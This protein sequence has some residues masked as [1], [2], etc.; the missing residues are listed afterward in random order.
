MFKAN[1]SKK[2]IAS[3]VGL[4][5]QRIAQILT[6][7]GLREKNLNYSPKITDAIGNNILSLNDKGL[8]ATE[9]SKIIGI[10]PQGIRFFLKKNNLTSNIKV[11]DRTRPCAVCGS[12]FT[13]KYSDGVKK[14]KYK[15]C[16]EECLHKHLSIVKTKYNEDDINKVIKLK[17]EFIPNNRISSETGIDINKIKEITKNY[18]LFLTKE[19]GQRNAYESKLAKNPN[20]I[21]DMKDKY[22][23][24]VRSDETLEQVKVQLQGMGFEYV[25]GFEIKSKPFTIKCLTCKKDKEICRINSVVSGSCLLCAK[26]GVSLQ[27]NA[28]K[29]WVEELGLKTEKYKFK[30]RIGGREIDVYV[31]EL[32]V[33]I[34]Y[35]GLYWHNECSPTPRDKKYHIGKLKKANNDGIRLITIFEDE[36]RDRKEQVKSFIFSILKS[37]LTIYARKTKI[38]EISTKITKNFLHLYHIQGT[39]NFEVAYGLLHNNE[40]VGLMTGNKHHRQTDTATKILVLNRLVFKNNVTVVGGASKLLSMLKTYAVKNGY[41]QIVTWSDNRWSEGNVYEKMGFTLNSTLPPDY[42]YVS[43]SKRLS[44][45]SCQKNSLLEKGGIGN[46]EHEMALSLGYYRIWDCGKKR[47]TIT[48]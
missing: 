18:S 28:I 22:G 12:L 24:Q 16:S 1:I 13:P 42:S 44:K 7:H 40:L 17:K 20:C 43:G 3:S 48:L 11:V 15:T 39:T 14:D 5:R 45:Q 4:T 2:D 32:K 36:W 29:E 30:E 41:E 21:A 23:K 8:T 35:C 46:T 47:W 31:P 9:I 25:S 10:T 37:S 26:T 19:Q 38:E 33:G 27:E 6:K 34:E